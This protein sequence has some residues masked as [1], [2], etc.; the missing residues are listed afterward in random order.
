MNIYYDRIQKCWYQTDTDAPVTFGGDKKFIA[1]VKAAG[2][3]QEIPFRMRMN[4]SHIG[5]L[6]GILAARKQNG[7]VAGNGSLFIEI[8]KRLISLNGISF[9]FT[10]EGVNEDGIAGYIF[11]PANNEWVKAVFPFPDLVYN[12]IPFRNLEQQED[13]KKIF[14]LLK[15]KNI[16]FFNP[17]FIDKQELHSLMESNPVLKQYLPRTIA[18]NQKRTVFHFLKKHKSIYMKPSQASKG[19]GI[20]RLKLGKGFKVKLEGIK[21][22]DIFPSFSHFWDEWQEKLKKVNYLAQ[23]E[24]KSLHYQGKRFDFRILAHAENGC[25]TVTGVGIRQSQ[26]QEITT[27]IPSGGRLLPYELFRSEETDQFIQTIVN[28]AGHALTERFGFFGEFSIDAGV[29]LNG[30]YYIYEI[31]SKPMSFDEPEIEELRIFQLCNL[32]LQIPNFQK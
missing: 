21:K 6:I 22:C 3:D 30:R 31:N 23:E 7:S 24:I 2:S 16:P 17:C 1:H 18:A 9:I 5:P 11:L 20:Y 26:A 27:H 12:R 25:Y 15:E 32:F 19:K 4:N 10:P 13:V 29:S 28:A 8:Q 14:S